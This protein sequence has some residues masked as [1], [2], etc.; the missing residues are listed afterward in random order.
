MSSTTWMSTGAGAHDLRRAAELLREV[1][2]GEPIRCDCVVQDDSFIGPLG[3]LVA[4]QLARGRRPPG[5]SPSEAVRSV[6]RGLHRRARPRF[7]NKW[8]WPDALDAVIGFASTGCKGFPNWQHASIPALDAAFDEWLRA[9]TR[10]A[11]SA[12]ASRAQRIAARSFPYVPLVTPNDVWVHTKRLRGFEPHPAD[13][14][15]L[16]DRAHFV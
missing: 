10:D 2:G 11:L 1:R 7:I 9:G 3:R 5:R 6:L 16:Y 8:L 4:K 13:L 12:A 14:Y 15:P